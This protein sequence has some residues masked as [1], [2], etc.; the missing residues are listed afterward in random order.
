MLIPLKLG[1]ITINLWGALCLIIFFSVMLYVKRSPKI[2]IYYSSAI[3]AWIGNILV[4]VGLAF[5]F[6]LI[7]KFPIPSFVALFIVAMLC[8]FCIVM[9]YHIKDHHLDY[10]K[11]FGKLYKAIPWVGLVLYSILEITSLIIVPA[12][13]V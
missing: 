2:G 6:N 10:G 7:Q 13:G 3:S 1:E 9:V 4:F 12:A 5:D 8:I 11:F